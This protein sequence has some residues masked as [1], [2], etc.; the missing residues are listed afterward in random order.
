M[1][2]GVTCSGHA[3][4]RVECISAGEQQKLRVRKWDGKGWC[5]V[6]TCVTCISLSSGA[7][8]LGHM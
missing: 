3:G 7:S 4:M 2:N 5:I 1:A 6:Q 8:F